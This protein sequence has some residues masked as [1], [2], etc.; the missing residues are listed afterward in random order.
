M[1]FSNLNVIEIQSSLNIIYKQLLKTA[2]RFEKAEAIETERSKRVIQFS[3]LN[4]SS[5]FFVIFK[6]TN[7][8]TSS[9]YFEN[10]ILFGD[11]SSAYYVAASK[12]LTIKKFFEANDCADD[13]V[14]AIKKFLN[15]S[16]NLFIKVIY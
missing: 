15:L 8:N 3:N 12:I 11:E 1:L 7:L 2:S 9:Q 10:S 6:T 13:V 16:K 4:L 5:F 14:Y